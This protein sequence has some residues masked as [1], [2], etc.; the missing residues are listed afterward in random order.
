MQG[1]TEGDILFLTTQCFV[2]EMAQKT[3]MAISS[4]KIN[5]FYPNF[6]HKRVCKSSQMT[7]I[8]GSPPM[9]DPTLNT[10][11]MVRLFKIKG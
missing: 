6:D 3:E 11:T 5:N 9:T 4:L 7:E 10:S 2:W 8:D 1:M